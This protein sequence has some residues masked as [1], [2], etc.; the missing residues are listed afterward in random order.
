MTARIHVD[1][2]ALARGGD[3]APLVVEYADGTRTSH[4]SLTGCG[5]YA[6]LYMPT[7]AADEHRVLLLADETELSVCRPQ[8]WRSRVNSELQTLVLRT[9]RLEEA[10][11]GPVLRMMVDAHQL[12]LL[13]RQLRVMIEY[14]LILEA[15]LA[16][17]QDAQ[18]TG[19]G[20]LSD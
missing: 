15:R 10:L 17:G 1:T 16:H 12:Q 19:F 14:R 8:N 4:V 2:T 11:T 13:E 9:G 18:A 6:L 7:A 20:A 5:S 3:V